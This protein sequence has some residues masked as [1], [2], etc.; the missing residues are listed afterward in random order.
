MNQ[1][2]Q[3]ICEQAQQVG[4]VD[5]LT[6]LPP[7]DEVS[8]SALLCLYHQA[9]RIRWDR[10]PLLLPSREPSGH[11]ADLILGSSGYLCSEYPLFWKTD[12][13]LRAR[14]GMKPDFLFISPDWRRAAFIEHKIGGGD[15]HKGDMYGGQFGRYLK[16]LIDARV[17][18][19][20]LVVL[21]ADAFI[22][23]ESPWYIRELEAARK[24]HSPDQKASAFV[25][26]WEKILSAVWSSNPPLEP[27]ARFR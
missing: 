14:G 17:T 18:E 4:F 22:M 11:N 26:T 16:Y 9:G 6:K 1:I 21:T 27:T 20:F 8:L 12:D 23:R 10:V 5:P 13:E 15:T 3:R 2:C 24:L 19:A 25:L 7:R